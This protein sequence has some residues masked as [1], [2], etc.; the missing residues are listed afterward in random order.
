MGSNRWKHRPPGSNWG[1]FG[2][3]DQT[4]CLNYLTAEKVLQGIAEVQE[5]LSFCLSLP[6][7]YPGGNVLNENRHPPMLRPTL[8]KGRVNFNCLFGEI[9]PGRTDVLN[10]D[11]VILH[12]QY[13][14]QWDGLGHV[15]S[16]F[17][18]NG[19]GV[20]EP[21]Y[22]NGYGAGDHIHGPAT[23]DGCGINR[24]PL[25]STSEARAL[26]IQ[27][28]AGKCV[29]TRGAMIDLKAHFGASRT[30]IGYDELMTVIDKDGIEVESGDIVCL[31]TGFAE[32]ILDM[33]RNPDPDVIST[34][35]AVLN[36]RDTR[37]LQWFTDTKIAALVADNC[38]VEGLPALDGGDCCAA[39]PLHEHCLFKIG[40]HL[41]ELWRL[42]PLADYLKAHGRYRFLLTAPPLNLPGAIASPATPIG[43]V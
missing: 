21:V 36:G 10:D 24:R 7:D 31:H 15:G 25:E 33:N 40:L 32:R 3:D 8:R 35:G 43:T 9:E 27:N 28:M 42:T 26:G 41:G 37:L 13:S 17:D 1:E 22:Y 23:V 38:A 2:P 19:D 34:Y 16:L 18:A 11:L 20:P 4:G 29:Q 39:L 30:Q 12:L 14:T 5:G 6:L